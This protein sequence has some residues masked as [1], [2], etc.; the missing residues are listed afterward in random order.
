VITTLS[1][2]A[3]VDQLAGIDRLTRGSSLKGARVSR[4]M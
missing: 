1:G 3:G 2:E 4:V